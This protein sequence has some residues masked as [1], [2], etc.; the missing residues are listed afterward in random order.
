MPFVA[1]RSSLGS[2]VVFLELIR[3]HNRGTTLSLVSGGLLEQCI[4]RLLKSC[5]Q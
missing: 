5:L 3:V 1:T 2:A 4:Y